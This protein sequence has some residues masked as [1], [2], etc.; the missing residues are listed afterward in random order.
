MSIVLGVLSLNL[1]NHFLD[2]SIVVLNSGNLSCIEHF[3]LYLG[4][5]SRD[6]SCLDNLDLRTCLVEN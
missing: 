4:C 5:G 3:F 6:V 1:F 2:L